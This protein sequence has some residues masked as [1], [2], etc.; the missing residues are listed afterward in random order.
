MEKYEAAIVTTTIYVPKLLDSYADDVKKN[1][2]AVLFIV[3]GD[4]KAPP[5]TTVYCKEL[6]ARTGVT[7]E[8][9]SVR[10]QEE[11]LKKFPALG[12]HIPYNCIERRDVGLVYAYEQN[13]ETIITIDDDNLRVTDDFVGAH[14]VTGERACDVVSSS[15]GWANVCTL[16][17]EKHGRRFYHRGFPVEMRNR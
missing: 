16:L 7:V 4:K 5:E 3:V 12:A 8:Y 6:A 9:F 14:Q 15:T 17:T 10:R 1:N 13:C 2:R 11:Y